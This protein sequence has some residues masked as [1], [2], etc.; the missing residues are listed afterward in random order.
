MP[1]SFEPRIPI[2]PFS[3][4]RA[5]R[6]A[7]RRG[8]ER[9]LP[10]QAAE[11][12]DDARQV[13]ERADLARLLAVDRRD[14]DLGEPEAEARRAHDQLGLDL[15]AAGRARREVEQRPAVE[16]VAALA[17]AHALAGEARGP[18]RRER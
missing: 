17:V 2:A 4:A 14:L 1:S 16:P 13:T 15:V 12:P 10:R 7:H 6:G 8:R 5:R 11:R 18:P 9:A 3:L